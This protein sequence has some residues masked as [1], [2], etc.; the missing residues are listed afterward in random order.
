MYGTNHQS[1]TPQATLAEQLAS[2][3]AVCPFPA[4]AVGSVENLTFAQRTA[5]D[6]AW[7]GK[8]SLAH[9]GP[10]LA[11][12]MHTFGRPWCVSAG[13]D[14]PRPDY[15]PADRAVDRLSGITSTAGPS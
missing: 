14:S 2:I 13:S 8:P 4:G 9:A 15:M 6:L 3:V 7:G 10:V 12:R 11:A 5:I 1:A